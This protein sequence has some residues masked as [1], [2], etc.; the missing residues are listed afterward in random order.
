[1][2]PPPKPGFLLGLVGGDPPWAWPSGT[3]GRTGI[4]FPLPGPQ[5]PHTLLSG[6]GLTG[7]AGY[8]HFLYPCQSGV[9]SLCFSASAQQ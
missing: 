2:P 6:R 9:I 8:I 4:G 3:W 5:V 7:S 1:M